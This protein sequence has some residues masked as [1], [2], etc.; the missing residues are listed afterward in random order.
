MLPAVNLREW[1]MRG[2]AGAVGALL[3]TLLVPAAAPAATIV[4]D[5]TADDSPSL[6]DS[7]CSLREAI[8]SVG[9]LGADDC[10]DGDDAA[11]DT[12]VFDDLGAGTH[13]ISAARDFILNQPMNIDASAVAGEVRVD[14]ASAASPNDDHGI[15]P[16]RDNILIKGLS[17]TNWDQTGIKIDTNNL[18]TAAVDGVQV[19]DNFIGTNKAG[20]A[21]LGNGSL[22]V[23]VGLPTAGPTRE[24]DN[25][26]V[27]GNVVSGNGNGISVRGD[28][29]LGTT[30]KDNLIGTTPAGTAAR[31]NTGFGINVSDGAD[32]VTIGGA[33]AGDGNVISG[34]GTQGVKL[35]AVGGDSTG[36]VVVRNNA[37]G[38]G[39]NGAALG[40]GSAGLNILGDVDGT[41]IQANTI[42]DN[43]AEGVALDDD[44]A[45]GPDNTFVRGNRI[46]TNLAGTAVIANTD[47]AVSLS[48]VNGAPGTSGT[49]IGGTVAGGGGCADPCNVIGG[50]GVSILHAAVEG[51]EILGNHIGVNTAG[52]GPLAVA[53]RGVLVTAGDDTVIG[54]P[55][56]A[57]TIGSTATAAIQMQGAVTGGTIQSNLIGTRSDG[58]GEVG[59]TNLGIELQDATG[60]LIGGT[61]AGEGNTIA[62]SGAD[63]VRVGFSGDDNPIVGNR[64][65]DNGGLGIDLE[66][67][68]GFGPTPNDI[69][70]SDVGA[71]DLQNHVT[72]SVLAETNSIRLIGQLR[73][74]PLTAFR[75]EVFT[76]PTPHAEG[77]GDGQEL[78]ESFSSITPADG[79]L[80]IDETV[81]GDLPASE[82]LSLTVTEL[83]GGGAPVQTSEFTPPLQH[84][85]CIDTAVSRDTAIV[86]TG[87]GETITGTAGDDVICALGGDDLIDGGGGSDL[88]LG[89]GGTDTI[90]MAA[91]SGPTQVDLTAETAIGLGSDRV[92][93]VEG[94][95]GS[96]FADTLIGDAGAN[97][98][99]GGGGGDTLT[100]RAGVDSLAGGPGSDTLNAADG[101]A[102]A[103][104]NCGAGT[105]VANGD[106]ASI[107]P[108]GIY[109]GC[110][111]INRPDQLAPSLKLGG[112]KKQADKRKVVV[113][114]TCENEVCD[115]VASGKIKIKVLKGKRKKQRIEAGPAKSK[116][117]KLKPAAI[118]DAPVGERQKLKLKFSRKTKK[119]IRKVIKR[120]ASTATVE[121]VA[122]DAAGNATSPSKRKVKVKR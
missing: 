54:S 28:Q 52:T 31:A 12:V 87:N 86:G 109:S 106:E 118:S 98:L 32:G 75:V 58:T 72:L 62:N 14:G 89:G 23:Q 33:I 84:G 110:E 108:D 107:D 15:Q 120:K 94:A 65:F 56:G 100:G 81:A 121:V 16:R 104:I 22:G 36:T 11:I 35:T 1:R 60:V 57:N 37:I 30:I 115:L 49:T 25:T 76:N 71:N 61:G 112:K 26:V 96:A 70:D 103:A 21:G 99:S 48:A 79:I 24:P 69:D 4:V 83:D 18:G 78:V 39:S 102:D 111:T 20:A 73:S 41:A 42:S 50:T 8:L 64:I 101:Q 19:I 97:S 105:D 9:S 17:V 59:N 95:A 66:D 47:A 27:E 46:G 92:I 116:T 114:A 68:G 63:G 93:G 119:L 91:A 2:V 67:S 117:L 74:T 6:S 5:T 13:V 44:V 10:E 122:T 29:T 51:T 85:F 88:I 53:G 38:L 113:V 55:S 3:L 90:S 45:A 40:N 80:T 34:N 77:F 82:D 43:G 7:N